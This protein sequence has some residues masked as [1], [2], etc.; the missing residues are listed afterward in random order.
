MVL[1]AETHS[2][3]KFTIL[4]GLVVWSFMKLKEIRREFQNVPEFDRIYYCTHQKRIV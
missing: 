2:E 1:G 3:E 4:L